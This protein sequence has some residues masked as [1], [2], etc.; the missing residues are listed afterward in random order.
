MWGSSVAIYENSVVS[1]EIF[2]K[3]KTS[4]KKSKSKKKSHSLLIN[5][6]KQLTTWVIF[7]WVYFRIL[8]HSMIYLSTLCWMTHCS[9]IINLE[10]HSRFI[11]TLLF[12]RFIFTILGPLPL[13]KNFKISLKFPTRKK[14]FFF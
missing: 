3:P 2:Y 12:F 5:F 1:A 4:L 7:M 8:L 6:K 13:Q 9:F 10:G 14:K 11:S